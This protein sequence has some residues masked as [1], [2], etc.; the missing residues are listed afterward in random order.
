MMNSAMRSLIRNEALN[1]RR[2]EY[3]TNNGDV[4]E[5]FSPGTEWMLFE[6][7]IHLSAAGDANN[8]VVS[9]GSDTSST[10]EEYDVVLLEQDMTTVTDLHW[11]PTMPIHLEPDDTI[12]IAWTNASTRVYG[13]EVVYSR[14]GI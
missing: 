1:K 13:I 2:K 8:L 5:S 12:D 11:Q 3:Y 14:V 10:A 4:D 9:I 7:R 6:I